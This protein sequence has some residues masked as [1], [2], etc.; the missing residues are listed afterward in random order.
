[1]CLMTEKT[2]SVAESFVALVAGVRSLPCVNAFMNHKIK[3][4][5]ETLAAFGT[6]VRLFSRV[7]SFV[8]KERGP[9]VENLVTF[10]AR[11]LRSQVG[12]LVLRKLA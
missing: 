8:E 11:V 1:M 12:L 9:P 10:R 5:A 4:L 7:S 2:R 3:T 6:S